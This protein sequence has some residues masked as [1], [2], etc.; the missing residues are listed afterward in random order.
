MVYDVI[1]EG[2]SLVNNYRGQFNT[3]L[4]KNPPQFLIDTVRK[5]VEQPKSKKDKS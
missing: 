3:I 1:I 2:V 5:K 4:A